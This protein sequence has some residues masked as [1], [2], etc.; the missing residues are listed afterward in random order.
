MA[1]TLTKR[2]R[3][4]CMSR[5]KSKWTSLEREAHNFLKG[6]RIC[7]KMHPLLAGNPDILIKPNII[8]FIHGCFWHKCPKCYRRPKSNRIYW[9]S[10]IKMNARRDKIIRK[11]LKKRGYSVLVL[12]EHNFKNN[13]YKAKINKLI[14]NRPISF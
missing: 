3:S 14:F 5:V 1:D 9:D 13:A 12:W 4:Y 7:H 2:Q 10:K 6:N 8:V 11:A